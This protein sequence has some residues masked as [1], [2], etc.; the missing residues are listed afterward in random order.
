MMKTLTPVLAAIAVA[1]LTSGAT[2][3]AE[4]SYNERLGE[5]AG[6]ER[7]ADYLDITASD[8]ANTLFELTLNLGA[9]DNHANWDPG[10]IVSF[11]DVA[12][13]GSAFEYSPSGGSGS[14]DEGL[15]RGD[16]LNKSYAELTRTDSQFQFEYSGTTGGAPWTTVTTIHAPTDI[17]YVGGKAEYKLIIETTT[18]VTNDTGEAVSVAGFKAEPM[19]ALSAGGHTDWDILNPIDGG[20][21]Y[22]N[23]HA[24]D[25]S[26]GHQLYAI[27]DWYG[28]EDGD[29]NDGFLVRFEVKDNAETDA[30]NLRPGSIFELT[31]SDI[32]L[33]YANRTNNNIGS[34]NVSSSHG[35]RGYLFNGREAYGSDLADG[36]SVTATST[37]EMTFVPEPASLALLGAGGALILM[38]R[39]ER[40]T[41]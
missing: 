34:T 31:N 14:S 32:S 10:E 30:L 36:D 24:D 25:S 3:A 16:Q 1:G 8:G 12:W 15:Y 2:H 7:T 13:G 41:A 19:L 9:S 23:V 37:L 22:P 26:D 4:L 28:T 27:T 11:K 6:G 5:P 18:T 35:L 33:N 20:Q 38:R 39:R 40:A 21:P 29:H 17:A